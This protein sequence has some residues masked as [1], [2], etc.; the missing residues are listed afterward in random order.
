MQ[1]SPWQPAR[2]CPGLPSSGV[3]VGLVTITIG[4]NDIYGCTVVGI[5]GT[6]VAYV[7]RTMGA[8]LTSM[9]AQIRAAAP[10]ALIVALTYYNPLLATSNGTPEA[11]STVPP[12][13]ADQQV[14]S[15]SAQAFA[16][17]NRA[18]TAAATAVGGRVA[19]VAGVFSVTGHIGYSAAGQHPAAVRLDHAVRRRRRPPQRRRIRSHGPRGDRRPVSRACIRAR[20]SDRV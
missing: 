6:C 20:G 13:P 14:T 17:L 4:V 1:L 8:A 9:L 3:G 10:L 19:D 7:T 12:R 18:I 2:R 15:D 5:D 16:A 11:P